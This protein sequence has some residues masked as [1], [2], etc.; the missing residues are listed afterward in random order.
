MGR[1]SKILVTLALVAIVATTLLAS[2][3]MVSAKEKEKEPKF[4]VVTSAPNRAGF[5][6]DG[7][8]KG[9]TPLLLTGVNPGNHTGKFVKAGYL[10]YTTNFS[11]TTKT[12]TLLS[13]SLIP[14]NVT[15]FV[16]T[17]PS[18]IDV[19]LNETYFGTTNQTIP[20]NGTLN[21]SFP[22]GG[23][24]VNVSKDG[25]TENTTYFVSWNKQVTNS[26][27]II[28]YTPSGVWSEFG[29]NGTFY[30]SFV[31]GESCGIEKGFITDTTI[32][33][34]SEPSGAA[35]LRGADSEA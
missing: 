26:T 16:L 19:F 20:G 18:G 31:P 10:D 27:R 15:L 4:L 2:A 21:I 13:A 5:Y 7:S 30:K 24:W 35:Y 14:L 3:D 29:A 32:N 9:T 34:T 11:V 33:A 25:F 17:H 8:Y 23:Y 1:R 12:V 28:C 22:A 6:L